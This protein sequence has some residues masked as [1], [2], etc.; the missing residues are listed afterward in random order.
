VKGGFLSATAT[1][2]AIRFRL[3]DVDGKVVYE[4]SPPAK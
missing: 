3:Y 2:A 1:A 4:W